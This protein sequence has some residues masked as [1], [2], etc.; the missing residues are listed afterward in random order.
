MSLR[1]AVL[2]AVA[3]CLAACSS[4][5][6][7][8]LLSQMTLE[9]KISLLRGAPEDEGTDQ[10]EAGYLPGIPRLRIPPM[11]FADGPPGVLTRYPATALTATMGLAATFSRE[12]AQASGVVIAR[13]ARTHGIDVVLQPFINIHRD[14]TFARAYNSYGED[15]LLT[16]VIGSALIR[17]VQGEGIMAQ[18]KHF[19]GYDGAN[20]VTVGDQALHEIY[21]AP[22][23][24]AVRVGVSSIMCSYNVINGA[25]SCGNRRLLTGVLRNELKFEGFVT[26]DWGAVHATPFVDAGDDLEM[27]GSGT[28]MD[29]YFE[30]QVP[31]PAAFRKPLLGPEVSPTPEELTQPAPVFIQ[32]V[33]MDRPMG[34]LTAL[35]RG[36]VSEATITQAARR[37][38]VQMQRFGLL[39]RQPTLALPTGLQSDR[40]TLANAAI[41][42]KTSEDAAVLLKNEDA[43][44]PLKF[45][46]AASLALI[47]PGA[48]QDIA[49]GESGEKALGHQERQVSPAAALRASGAMIAEAVADD[50]SGSTIPAQILVSSNGAGLTR[51][52]GQGEVIGQD[53][54]LDFTR[55]RGNALPAGTNASWTGSLQI[56]QG[57]RYRLYLQVLGASAT[58]EVDGVRTAHSGALQLHGNVLQPGQDNVLPSRDGLDNVRRELQ[59]TAGAH[60]L[61]VRVKAEAADQPVQ[62]RLAWV[63]PSQRSADYEEAINAAAHASKAIVFAWSRG[64]PIFHLP[65]DQDQL[66]ADVAAV[67]PNTVVVLNISEPIAMP[68]LEQV[69]AVLLMWYPGDEGG[70]ATADV[71]LGHANPAGR[72]PFTWP[73]TLEQNVANDPAHPERSSV[74]VNGRTNYS[75]GIFVGYRWFDQQQL[76]PQ[77]PFGYGLSYS[78]FEYADLRV[79]PALD[80]GLEVNCQLRNAGDIAGDE[81]VQLYVG[82]P[83]HSPTDTQFAAR[84]LAG[85]ERIHLAAGETRR[86]SLHVAARALQYWSTA[87]GA[88]IIAGGARTVYVGA[89]ERDLRLRAV[90]LIPMP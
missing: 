38:L 13:D 65:G 23:A 58:L 48:L 17:G 70:P 71:L 90:T 67:N 43:A 83:T 73:K 77:Y 24:E 42:R 11:R 4:A 12:D 59:L 1:F 63:P 21:L 54:Q 50:M 32:T 27:P 66:I 36:L 33:P 76:E 74:G 29:S 37:I 53:A 56:A 46:K 49:A 51:R 72:L 28:V 20:D 19:I 87:R 88:W 82:A 41:V 60:Q 35:E 86:V 89:S 79:H 44:L 55:A 25:Y 30:G 8:Q 9:E 40:M 15:P 68:W 26:S 84:A 57:G 34:M 78:R 22:F 45:T 69:K 31:R 64:R 10:G 52:D 14:Q 61:N 16:G 81:V 62:V 80:G 3:F 47:G 5:R 7:D 18:A 6:V 85:F 75:E 39:D 2:G